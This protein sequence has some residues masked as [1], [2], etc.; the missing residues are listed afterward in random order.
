MTKAACMGCL[1]AGV[2]GCMGSLADEPAAKPAAVPGHPDAM[3]LMAAPLEPSRTVVYKAVAGRDLH[4]YVFEPA[5]FKATDHRPCFVTIHGGGWVNGA[6]RRMFPFAAHAASNGM[7]GI[8]VEYRLLQAGSPVTVFDCVRDGRSAL[9]YI[10]AHA[11]RFGVD[12][13]KLVVQGGSAGGHVA[14]GTALFDGVDEAGE[15][16]SLSCIPNA[17]VLLFPVIDTSKEGYGNARI[18]ERWQELSPLHHVR[19]GLPPTLVFHGTG[20]R[21]CPF[22]GAQAFH[23]AM[24]KAGNRCD[25]DVNEGGAHG[26]LM[27]S[28]DLYEDTQR[29]TDA[30]LVSLG[31]SGRAPEVKP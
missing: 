15:D 16:T 27:R 2:M 12:P 7:V 30:F 31:L 8:S 13:Q 19:A 3:D 28:R 25:L 18:G 17:M 26:Y 24:V 29:K 9:R 11:A 21:T 22:K 6:P 1:V 4:L 14:A 5:G 10:R 20:D 23:D